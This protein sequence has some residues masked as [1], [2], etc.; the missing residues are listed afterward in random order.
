M[1]RS[2]TIYKQ[3]KKS[4][5]H[6]FVDFDVRGQEVTNLFTGRS[7]ITDYGLLFWPEGHLYCMKCY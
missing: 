2:R 4:P 5:K 7:V 6:V 1:H 3:K